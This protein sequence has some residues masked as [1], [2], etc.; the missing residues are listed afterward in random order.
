MGDDIVTWRQQVLRDLVICSGE[1]G[2]IE[3]VGV[4]VASEEKELTLPQFCCFFTRFPIISGRRS[5]T[6]SLR[7]NRFYEV[8]RKGRAVARESDGE[9]NDRLPGCFRGIIDRRFWQILVPLT[10]KRAYNGTE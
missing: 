2:I 10:M 6:G 5:T 7:E 3:L 1:A 8:G 4:G 9:E